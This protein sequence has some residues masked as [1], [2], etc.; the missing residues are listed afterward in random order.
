MTAM[1]FLDT[2]ILLYKVSQD[3]AEAERQANA[4]EILEAD[5]LHQSV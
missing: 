5:D 2:N 4:A 3:P 1:R